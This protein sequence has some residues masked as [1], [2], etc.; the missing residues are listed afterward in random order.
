LS[1]ETHLFSIIKEEGG[2]PT[3][4]TAYFITLLLFA[5]NLTVRSAASWY[6]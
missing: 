1:I 4:I 6:L 5:A 2:A 3:R